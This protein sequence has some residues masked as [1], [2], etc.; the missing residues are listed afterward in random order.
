MHIPTEWVYPAD[1]AGY[2]LRMP[3]D[4]LVCGIGLG[5]VMRVFVK[6]KAGKEV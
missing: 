3:F 2:I 4:A 6:I 5:I 1:L